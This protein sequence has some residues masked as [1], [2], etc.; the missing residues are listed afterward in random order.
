M[1]AL[2]L[3]PRNLRISSASRFRIRLTAS[4]LG[5]INSLPGRHRAVAADVE[6]EEVEALFE[7]DDARLVLV[8]D[9]A[10]RCQPPGKLRLDLFRLLPGIAAGDHVVGVP[11]QNRGARYRRTGV[12]T[13]RLR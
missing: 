4:G 8:E 1:T 5:L 7:V 12:H 3:E 10:P 2:A 6:S 13:G 11:D 9:Q